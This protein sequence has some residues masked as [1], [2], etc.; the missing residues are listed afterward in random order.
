MTTILFDLDGTLIDSTDAI[1]E[2]FHVSFKYFDIKSPN[3]ELIKSLIGHPLDIMYE[4]LGVQKSQI[5]S[6]IAEYKKHYRKISSEQTTLL[7]YVKEALEEAKRFS[8]LGIVTTKTKRYSIE[9]LEHL[10]ILHYF[11]VII[12]REDVQNPKP[13]PEPVLKA[14][15]LLN[16]NKEFAWM[17]GDTPMDML[18]ANEA[19][20]KTCAVLCGYGTKDALESTTSNIHQNSHDAVKFIRGNL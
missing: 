16:C 2:S 19:G 7:P 18:S 1:L 4:E 11:T 14:L 13:H 3:D 8:T 17:I 6:I 10:G 15:S 9:L 12:G 5:D 20:I